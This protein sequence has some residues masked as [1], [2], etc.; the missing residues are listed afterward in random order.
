MILEDK[1]TS[2]QWYNVDKDNRR[3]GS[4]KTRTLKD[5]DTKRPGYLKVQGF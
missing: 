5:K 1:D 4:W 3:Q 2:R